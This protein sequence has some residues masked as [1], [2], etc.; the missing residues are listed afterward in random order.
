M[1]RRPPCILLIV[2]AAFLTAAKCGGSS[3]PSGDAAVADASAE[4]AADSISPDTAADV[5]SST[6][7]IS[8]DAWARMMAKD[9][10]LAS[11]RPNTVDCADSATRQEQLTGAHTYTVN[12]ANCNYLAASQP[13]MAPIAKGDKL[14]L[15][16]YH[17]DLDA[18]SAAEAHVA[19]LVKGDVAWQKKV[20]IPS[21]GEVMVESWNASK[22]YAA[23]DEVV[24]HLH[25]H[26]SNSWNFIAFTNAGQ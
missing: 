23:G 18:G 1:T 14:D 2:C 17:A 26:G 7:L 13:L 10:P 25:N 5:A 4:D 8:N 22:S 16:I 24:F 20:P 12:T 3:E 15:R 21:D 6:P 9:D 11:H 19:V